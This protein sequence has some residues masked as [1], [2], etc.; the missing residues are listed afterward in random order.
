MQRTRIQA[1]RTGGEPAGRV[2]VLVVSQHDL[3]RRQ[4]VEYLSRSSA[5]AV[6]G[7]E[8]STDAIVHARPDVVVL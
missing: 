8:L 3:V 5:L 2:R 4:L 7:D 1:R 6:D